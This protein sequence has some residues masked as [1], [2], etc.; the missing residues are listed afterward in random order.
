MKVGPPRPYPARGVLAVAAAGMGYC[1]LSPGVARSGGGARWCFPVSLQLLQC[2]IFRPAESGAEGGSWRGSVEPP[3]PES[4]HISVAAEGSV[5]S[6][7]AAARLQ[8][9][10]PLRVKSTEV[11]RFAST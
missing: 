1:L 2:A 9:G 7:V 8:T 4:T 10:G 11:P 5:F 6:P 3:T